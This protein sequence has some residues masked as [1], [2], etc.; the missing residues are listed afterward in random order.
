MARFPITNEWYCRKRRVGRKSGSLRL[1]CCQATETQEDEGIQPLPF[2]L[3]STSATSS[4]QASLASSPDLHRQ[5]ASTE[6]PVD[7]HAAL[8]SV[9]TSGRVLNNPAT[10]G[11]REQ[12]PGLRLTKV[13]SCPT[14]Q[15]AAFDRNPQAARVVKY[16][17]GR[18]GGD[19]P[20]SIHLLSQSEFG[21]TAN[22]GN[23]LHEPDSLRQGAKGEGE[24]RSLRLVIPN[25][26][27]L[28]LEESLG[29]GD[30]GGGDRYQR[31]PSEG[32]P[33]QVAQWEKIR[34]SSPHLPPYQSLWTAQVL[35]PAAA[36]NAANQQ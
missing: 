33:P 5:D 13:A 17:R 4:W 9:S 21:V 19:P 32:G 22:S 11:I 31:P 14:R 25:R 15:F 18:A 2:T 24:G 3:Q 7:D 35:S 27:R 30:D 1:F 12:D 28:P 6:P 16:A 29:D 20:F 36:S 23:P 10:W 34:S 26:L 8:I